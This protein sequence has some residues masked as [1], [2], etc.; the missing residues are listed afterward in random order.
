MPKADAVAKHMKPVY[1]Q[2]TTGL[3]HG[4]MHIHQGKRVSDEM[5]HGDAFFA[6]TE[7]TIYDLDGNVIDQAPFVAV[8]KANVVWIRPDEDRS[9]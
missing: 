4:H 3:L 1:V 8:G 6:L 7:A 2:T 5:N 9:H